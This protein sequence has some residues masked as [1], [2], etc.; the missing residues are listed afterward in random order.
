MNKKLLSFSVFLVTLSIPISPYL[1]LGQ[2]YGKLLIDAADKGDLVQV[3]KLL[4]SGV[5]VNEKST[6]SGRTAL[7][8]AAEEGHKA[9]VN[10][11]IANGANVNA[12]NR[13][14]CT[15]LMYAAINGYPDIVKLLINHGANVNIKD[16]YGHTALDCASINLKPDYP[17]HTQSN[18]IYRSIIQLLKNAG[19]R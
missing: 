17:I 10:L 13:T 15:A 7:M 12:Q 5:N 11:L 1:C 2:V 18:K 4:A 16:D 6:K 3:N 8:V 9:I 19:A 14:G